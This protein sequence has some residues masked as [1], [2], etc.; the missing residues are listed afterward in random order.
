MDDPT[1]YAKYIAEPIPWITLDKGPWLKPTVA[2]TKTS[3]ELKI[4]AIKG[5]QMEMENCS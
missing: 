4:T 1:F 2:N 5:L 3:H